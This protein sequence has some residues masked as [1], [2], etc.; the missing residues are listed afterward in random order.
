MKQV[1]LNTLMAGPTS[2][3][4]PGDVIEVSDEQA[5]ALLAGKY[6]TLVETAAVEAPEKAVIPAAKRR[7]LKTAAGKPKR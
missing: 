5:A 3:G 7:K 6:A 1:K 4:S 2:S